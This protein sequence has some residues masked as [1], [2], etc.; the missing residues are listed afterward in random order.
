MKLLESIRAF[1]KQKL[2]LM[3]GA[4]LIISVLSLFSLASFFVGDSIFYIGGGMFLVIALIG[5][6]DRAKEDT[7]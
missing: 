1:N 7:K 2:T 4:F 3:Q 6:L 5:Y